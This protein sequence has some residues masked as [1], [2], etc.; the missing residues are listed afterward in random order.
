[1]DVQKNGFK[2]KK[3]KKNKEKSQLGEGELVGAKGTTNL[4]NPEE[5]RETE[6]E[7]E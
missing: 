3:E 1:M 5:E 6:S 7:T 4:L 2:G